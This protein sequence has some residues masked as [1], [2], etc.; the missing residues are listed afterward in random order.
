MEA[1]LHSLMINLHNLLFFVSV[2][3]DD[4][5]NFSHKINQNMD[6]LKVLFISMFI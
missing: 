6:L 2:F 4:Y 1:K 3:I 5:T